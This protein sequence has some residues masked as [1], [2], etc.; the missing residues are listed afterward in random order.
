MTAAARERWGEIDGLPVERYVLERGELRATFTNYG[1]ALVALEVPDRDGKRANVVLGFDELADYASAENPYFGGLIGRCANRIAHA[2]FELDGREHLLAANEGRHHLHGGARGFDRRVWQA[3][4]EPLAGR[5]AFTRVSPAG[6]EGYPGELRARATYRLLEDGVLEL[7]I[8]AACDAP[9]LWNP[10]QHAY[11]NLAGDGNSGGDVRAHVLELDASRYL[12]IDEELLPT[13]R[14]AHVDG[15]ALDLR[16]AT[17]RGMRGRG[18]SGRALGAVIAALAG[19]PAGGLDHGFVLDASAPGRLVR[20]GRLADPR[21][22]RVLELATTQPCLQV[23]TGNN[24]GGRFAR[25]GGVC[26]E[27]QGYTDAIH[28]AHFPSIV[29]RPGRSWRERTMWKFPVA[30]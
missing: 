24:L 17:D 16:A 6:E 11:W 30:N 19:T 21:S 26:L 27:P 18:G 22:G 3:E 9:T 10:T 13:G 25:H 12:E 2:R 23:Y 8:E 28:H 5:I 15:T 14:V 4:Y 29:L 20:A 7:E 1:A